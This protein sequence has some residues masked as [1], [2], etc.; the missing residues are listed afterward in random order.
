MDVIKLVL[1]LP[2]FGVLAPLLGGVLKGRAWAQRLVFGLMCFM[3]INGLFGPGNWGVTVMSIETYR[4]HTKGF[5][6][7]FNHG[8]AIALIVA[9]WLE[10]PASLR[11]LPPGL[12]LYFLYCGVSMLSVVNADRPELTWMAAHKMVFAS[13]IF[14]A[15]FQMLS[16]DEDIEY[17][18]KVMCVTMAW[19]LLVVLKLK[20][21]DGMYQVRGTFEH[22]NPLAM[23]AVLI[24]MVFLATGLGPGYRGANLA[25]FGFVA[26]A[27]VVQSTLSRAALA[28]FGAGTVAVML[29]SLAERPTLRRGVATAVVGVV[30]IIGLV[31]SLD[32]ILARF[33]DEGNVASGELRQVM[34]EAS[35]EMARDYKLG[36]GWNHYALVVNPPYRYADFYWEWIRG[37]GMKVDTER[38]NAVVESHYYLLLGETGWPGLLAY[39]LMV[40]VAL[41]RNGL[42]VVQLGHSFPRCL[43]LG[44]GVGC[45]LN[46]GQ[47][48]LERV[49]VQPRNLM[50]W[51]ILMGVSA[52]LEV[53]RREARVL[54]RSAGRRSVPRLFPRQT[55]TGLNSLHGV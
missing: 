32:T 45:L 35:R 17:F 54:G 31:L 49:L 41:W 22:Q 23:Y 20:Y 14:L 6:F 27:V 26:C 1:V 12:G 50:L 3:T 11:K 37:R 33:R 39:L 34:N 48:T 44:I 8:L 13:V 40:G 36:V 15:A 51:L 47:S 21:V 28:A 25:L 10:N 2:L 42:A 18:L 43:A 53:R 19:E 16:T 4:G 5:H 38:A 9:K 30:G 52:R 29:V 46:Y 7:Y 24:G 55:Q